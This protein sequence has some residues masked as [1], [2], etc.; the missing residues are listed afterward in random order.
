[1][2]LSIP[3]FTQELLRVKNQLAS[4]YRGHDYG[5]CVD[6]LVFFNDSDGDFREFV[7]PHVAI[8]EEQ[9]LFIAKKIEH[10]CRV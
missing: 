6:F 3:Q 2:Q 8:V 10:V 9:R 7:G 1:M 5:F 4:R